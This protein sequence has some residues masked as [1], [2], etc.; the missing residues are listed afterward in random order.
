MAGQSRQHQRHEEKLLK[1]LV[2]MPPYIEE[3]VDD[4]LEHRS[5]T[6]LLNYVLDYKSFFEWL[7]VENLVSAK[8]IKDIKLTDLEVISLEEAKNFFKHLRRKSIK[9]TNQETK[10]PEENSVSRKISSLRSLFKYLSSETEITKDKKEKFPYL[11]D[12]ENGEPYFHRN[13]MQ[14]IQVYKEKGTLNSRAK[15]I[16]SKILHDEEDVNL[17]NYIKNEYENKLPE[18]SRKRIF[19]LRDKERDFSILSLFLASGIRV[20]ELANLRLRDIDFSTNEIKVIRKGNKEDIV[21][22]FPESML[23]LKEY[24]EVRK[25]RYLGT[26]LPGDYV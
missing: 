11:A 13:V 18:K 20:N 24:L 15:K 1:L 4:K 22:V 23:D 8:V 10:K 25:E 19:F 2:V 16:S 9:L 12:K 14:K 5:P 21:A 6:T 3:Y 17:L 26:D 7:I